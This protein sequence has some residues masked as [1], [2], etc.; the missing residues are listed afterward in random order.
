MAMR[1][2]RRLALL[3]AVSVGINL[4]LGGMLAAQWLFHEPPRF[5]APPPGGF[6]AGPFDRQAGRAAIDERYRDAVDEIWLRNGRTFI[7][8][9]RAVKRARH[10]VRD[11]LLAE[12]FD[13]EAVQRAREALDQALIEASG[14]MVAHVIALA[15]ALPPEQR[16]RYLEA[17]MKRRKGLLRP[18][19]P[20]PHPPQGPPPQ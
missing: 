4:F 9:G 2:T 10:A 17:S 8:K 15:E 16:Q 7:E 14:F 6:R 3:L 1:L 13:P 12:R 20:P 19:G 11:Q 5:A 18:D